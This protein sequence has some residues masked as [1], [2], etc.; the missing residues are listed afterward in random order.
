MR[1]D[2]FSE[3]HRQP[4]YPD[5]VYPDENPYDPRAIDADAVR[6]QLERLPRVV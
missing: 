1:P 6:L 2:V 5:A 3:S 4:P